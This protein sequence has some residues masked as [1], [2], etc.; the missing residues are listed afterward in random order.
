M[1]IRWGKTA[2][3]MEQ[4]L[5]TV[6]SRFSH[7]RKIPLNG[8]EARMSILKDKTCPKCGEHDALTICATVGAVNCSCCMEFIRV[9]TKEERAKLKKG[10][11]KELKKL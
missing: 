11:L 9:L 2:L 6:T 4:T 7:L 3:R 5:P 8:R 10:I 1:L